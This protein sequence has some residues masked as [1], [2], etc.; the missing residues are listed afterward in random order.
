MVAHRLLDTREFNTNS[1]DTLETKLK[2]IKESKTQDETIRVIISTKSE[3]ENI[4]DKLYV[5]VLQFIFAPKQL[6][7]YHT[8]FCLLFLY[9]VT[10]CRST[11]SGGI[12]G[13]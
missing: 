6:I 13:Q 1:S 4:V 10:E 9:W 11:I 3:D 2:W 12:C 5:V 8:S 7:N